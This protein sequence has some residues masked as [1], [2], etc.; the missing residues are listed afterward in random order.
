M[1]SVGTALG[2]FRSPAGRIR[3]FPGRQGFHAEGPAGAKELAGAEDIAGAV[4]IAS[5]G[6]NI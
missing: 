5:V 3:G 4:T 6:I 1:G 2:G